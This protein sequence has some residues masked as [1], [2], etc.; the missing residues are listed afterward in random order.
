M[1]RSGSNLG[2]TFQFYKSWKVRQNRQKPLKTVI[3]GHPSISVKTCQIRL[4]SKPHW[5]RPPP[6]W[7]SFGPKRPFAGNAITVKKATSHGR[8]CCN[9]YRIGSEKRGFGGSVSGW[10]DPA[11][12]LAGRPDFWTFLGQPGP[13]IPGF[14]HFRLF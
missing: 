14:L 4:G 12:L 3:S 6:F 8:K 10:P 13:Q 2:G 1:A 7:P 5:P 11:I 9:H